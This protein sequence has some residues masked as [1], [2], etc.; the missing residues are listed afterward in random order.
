M[1][2]RTGPLTLATLAVFTVCL[3][4]AAQ[5]PFGAAQPPADPFGQAPGADP[6][7]AAKPAPKPAAA[8]VEAE[9]DKNPVVLAI[10]DLNPTTP[11]DLMFAVQTLFDIGRTD[12]AKLYLKKLMEAKPDRGQMEAFHRQY[13]S[14]FFFRLSRDH[15]MKPEGEQFGKAV[16]D[17]AYESA[18]DPKRLEALVRQLSDPS[19]VA[20]YDALEELR[21][22]GEAALPP[23]LAA[24]ADNARGSEQA[25]LRN[26][27]VQIG[28]TMIEPLLGAMGTPDEALRGQVMMILGQFKTARAIPYFLVPS[29]LPDVSETTRRAAVEALTQS[30]GQLP[31]KYEAERYLFRRA[32]E[33]LEGALAGPLDYEDQV[34]L[35]HWDNQKK[36]SVPGKYAPAEA[37]RLMAARLA[38]E[39]YKLTPDHPE[40]RRLYLITTLNDA[41]IRT[42]L[43]RPLPREKG[44]VYE[45]AA[46]LGP[47]T[48]E[49]VLAYAMGEGYVTA[50]IAAAEVLGDV[51]TAEL[52]QSTDGTPRPLAQAMRHSDRRLRL[53]AAE[54]I[55][56]LDPRRP[57][58]GSS[59]LPETFGYLIRTVGSRR[60][61]V[62]QPRVAKAQTLI[63]MLNQIGLEA[64]AAQSGTETFRLARNNPD[65][66]FVLISDAIDSPDVSETIQML[67]KDPRTNRLPVGLMARRER[68]EQAAEVAELDPLVLSFPR[69]HT[70]ESMAFQTARL[71][72][73]AGHERVSYDERLD[74]A[75]RSLDHLTRL[76]QAPGEYAFYDLHRHQQA[77]QSALFTPPLAV[78][79]AALLGLIGSPESQRALVT[80]ASQHARPLA[81]REAAARGFDAAVQRHGLLL[82]RDEILEQYE[83]YNRSE[84]LDKG[85]QQVLASLLDTIERPSQQ[86][87]EQEVP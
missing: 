7:R 75:A 56:K 21:R 85:T 9:E 77:V 80:V 53:A 78:K 81:E 59:Y 74:Q 79:A 34:T 20:Q 44:T 70:V 52:L 26:A 33:Y 60:V 68:L 58:A 67:R 12:D 47:D 8:P 31:T 54:A 40:F 14:D 48:M 17:A 87:P 4:L 76:A 86:A 73:L 10:R 37:S 61:L 57:Y 51:G 62:A 19:P 66:E 64:D 43:D 11:K 84:R 82:T 3:P 15:R 55:V 45:T 83:R 71:L 1:S 27:V 41:K 18:R 38:Q 65:Y 63:G 46:S 36:T 16:R 24:L 50:A 6:F 49:D 32:K 22:A 39:L 5:D 25:A 28:P 42:G 30:V 69:P 13:G 35:W 29:L 72:D 2:Q 23:I